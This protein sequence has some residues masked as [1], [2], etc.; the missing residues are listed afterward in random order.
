MRRLAL[1][2]A[3][4]AASCSAPPGGDSFAWSVALSDLDVAMR[5][6]CGEGDHII[7]VGGRNRG[8]VYE[9]T[10][11]A[12]IAAP[13][14]SGT[15]RLWWCW[16]DAT[17]AGF[18]VGERGTIVSRAATGAWQP[19]DDTAGAI[20]DNVTLY[21]VWGASPT[22]VTVVGG[23]FNPGDERTYVVHYDG[24]TWTRAD[25]ASFP[26]EALFK[27]WGTGGDDIWVVGTGGAILH[28]D[29]DAWTVHTSPVT[30]RLIAVW[31]TASDDVYAVGGDGLG[32]VLHYDGAAWSQIASTPERLSGVW[33]GDGR[34]VYVAGDR[35]YLARIDTSD[36]TR[37]ESRLPL[38]NVDMH[39][40]IGIG[41]AIVACG[42]DLL[43]GGDPSWRGAVVAHG[44]DLSGDVIGLPDAGPGPDAS[45]VDAG[46]ADASPYP[47]PGEL[48]GT[49]PNLCRPGIFCWG[50]LTSDAY[51]CTDVCNTASECF[52]YGPDACCAVP[53]FQTL[54]KVC[55]PAG[56]AEC[57]STPR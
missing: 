53:G 22:D 11:D 35:G 8:T 55:I 10:G 14:P 4:A 13:L 6:V 45:I 17:G 41:G 38:A 48:C 27:V 12:W 24:E 23:G 19:V 25:T 16:V 1:L 34:Y 7:A 15:E 57:N 50:L 29:G 3:V 20:P 5:A 37:I 56:Y 36:P 44:A 9:W 54:E 30:D 33:A 43:S 2:L 31:G 42:A 52:E 47:G 46:P 39:S 51:I 32:A 18:A 49:P 26:D 28:Y 40:I 21:G